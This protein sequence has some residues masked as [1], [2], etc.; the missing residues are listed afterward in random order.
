MQNS[1]SVMGCDQPTELMQFNVSVCC[2]GVK[3]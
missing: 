2:V 1:F 3:P